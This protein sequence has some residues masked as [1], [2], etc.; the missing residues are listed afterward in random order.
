MSFHTDHFGSRISI[1]YFFWPGAW[2]KT[3]FAGQL[4]ETL[5]LQIKHTWEDSRDGPCKEVL[6]NISGTSLGTT[7]IRVIGLRG[8]C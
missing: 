6:A 5:D 2:Y 4:H 8:L 7:R 3:S 1:N